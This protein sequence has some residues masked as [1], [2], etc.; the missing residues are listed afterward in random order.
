VPVGRTKPVMAVSV[1]E[2][3]GASSWPL[4]RAI[5]NTKVGSETMM[6]SFESDLA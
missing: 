5:S 4:W 1:Y 3:D 2:I 6:I